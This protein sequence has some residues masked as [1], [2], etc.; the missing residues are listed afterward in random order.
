MQRILIAT[1]IA[2]G[3][4][5]PAAV[6][7]QTPSTGLLTVYVQVLAQNG[8]AQVY[9]PANV[10]VSVAGQSPSPSS[11]A[12]SQSG[13]AV[14]LLPGSYNVTV[15]NSI[16][17]YTPTYSVGCNYSIGAGQTQNC[18]IS[19]TPSGAY[20]PPT[21]N[22]YPYQQQPL[23]CQANLVSAA[24][25]QSVTF[26]ALGGGGG[27]YN[28]STAYQNYP[29]VGPA[30]TVAFQASGAQ[31]V[32]VTS[33]P[34]TAQCTVNVTTTYYPGYQNPGYPT[35]TNPTP[36]Y[37]TAYPTYPI[38]YPRYPSSGFAPADMATAM[39]FATVMLVAAGI[40]LAPYVRRT[41]LALIG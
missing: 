24:L 40:I 1:L 7:A 32:T 33:G 37:T 30:L 8:H 22:P 20:Y 28:W 41:A 4:L 36:S 35:Y 18:I 39:A 31:V 34:Q 29:N 5:V 38:T 26:R 14:S 9:T 17:S 27:T 2:F 11:F 25:G 10:T 16:P 12:G 21:T 15:S 19:L 23:T 6:F 13:T 3:I